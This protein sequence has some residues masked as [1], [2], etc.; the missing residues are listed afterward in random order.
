VAPPVATT[1]EPE[2]VEIPVEL[3]EGRT[4]GH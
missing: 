1:V 3:D 4:G 2:S